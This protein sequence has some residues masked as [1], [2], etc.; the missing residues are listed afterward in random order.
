MTNDLTLSIHSLGKTRI[1]PENPTAQHLQVYIGDL[2]S[3]ESGLTVAIRFEIGN[4]L[5]EMPW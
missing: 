3:L 5:M 1:P 4:A 2:L